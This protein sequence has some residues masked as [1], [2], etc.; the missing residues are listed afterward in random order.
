MTGATQNKNE[1]I[2]YI[3][4]WCGIRDEKYK[5]WKKDS[6]ARQVSQA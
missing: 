1:K 3:Y 6:S 5:E 2:I 4:I